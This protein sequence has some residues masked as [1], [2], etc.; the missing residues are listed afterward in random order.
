MP[1]PIRSL[2]GF[3][4]H[5]TSLDY[6]PHPIRS[7]EEQSATQ[8]LRSIELNLLLNLRSIRYLIE[9]QSAA[10]QSLVWQ[11]ISIT[12]LLYLFDFAR[13]QDLFLQRLSRSPKEAK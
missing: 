3:H 6:T 10:D 11:F 7:I 8:S 5:S 9:E 4:I 1:H 13:N 2:L 12:E